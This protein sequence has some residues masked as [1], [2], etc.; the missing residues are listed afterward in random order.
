MLILITICCFQPLTTKNYEWIKKEKT[1][2]NN[3][4]NQ[5]KN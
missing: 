2:W 1:E 3:F 5:I 4:Q